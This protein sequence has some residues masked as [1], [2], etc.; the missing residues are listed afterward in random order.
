MGRVT[1]PYLYVNFK[2]YSLSVT[3][4]SDFHV[5]YFLFFFQKEKESMVSVHQK[6][7]LSVFEVQPLSLEKY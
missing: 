5:S 7:F 4:F 6:F 3:V 1:S 2:C